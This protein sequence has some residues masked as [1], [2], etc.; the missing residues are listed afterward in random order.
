MNKVEI[1]YNNIKDKEDNFI[2][3]LKSMDNILSKM[4]SYTRFEFVTENVGK[5][6]FNLINSINK[7]IMTLRNEANYYYYNSDALTEY[8]FDQ[9]RDTKLPQEIE[10]YYGEE[11]KI[12][13]KILYEFSEGEIQLNKVE[14]VTIT[15]LLLYYTKPS[16]I[17]VINEE[18]Y[19]IPAQVYLIETILD[20]S[21]SMINKN[22][23][24]DDNFFENAINEIENSYEE[25]LE[26]LYKVDKKEKPIEDQETY[27]RNEKTEKVNDIFSNNNNENNK[28]LKPKENVY[29]NNSKIEDD[30]KDTRKISMWG[31]EDIESLDKVDYK[32]KKENKTHIPDKEPSIGAWGGKLTNRFEEKNDSKDL[33]NKS[34][35]EKDIDNSKNTDKNLKP[36]DN[37]PDSLFDM[38]DD[39]D[40]DYGW[41]Q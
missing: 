13:I 1:N 14:Y 5:L 23:K 15:C 18:W 4:Y 31:F 41:S 37:L 3:K 22:L 11:I 33:E 9:L 36:S 16:H 6:N 7:Y 25:E 28:N 40:L 35:S 39:D 2:K 19:T 24:I 8:I 20:I 27:V 17:T 21:K 10:K 38:E 32:R 30:T 34:N 26:D 29:E 12:L